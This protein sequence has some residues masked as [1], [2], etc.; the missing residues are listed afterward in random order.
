M[1]E[2]E[3]LM[4]SLLGMGYIPEVSPKSIESSSLFVLY[5]AACFPELICEMSLDIPVP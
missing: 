4:E 1:I 2:Q 5:I 3:T